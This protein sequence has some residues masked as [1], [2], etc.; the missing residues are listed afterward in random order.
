MLLSAGI[1][2]SLWQAS[3]VVEVKLGNSSLLCNIT[4]TLTLCSIKTN[5]SE[6]F[7]CSYMLP[8]DATLLLSNLTRSSFTLG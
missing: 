5:E 4:Q 7:I 6:W 1:S 8:E 3:G 2:R